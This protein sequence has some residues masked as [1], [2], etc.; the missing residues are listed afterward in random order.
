MRSR[1]LLGRGC[2]RRCTS[3]FWEGSPVSVAVLLDV[4]DQLPVFLGRPWTLLEAILVTARCPSHTRI[5]RPVYGNKRDERKGD[6]IE[7]EDM[8]CGIF[9]RGDVESI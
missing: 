3:I 5:V 6:F 7:T 1:V 9:C 2:G 8:S 4:I